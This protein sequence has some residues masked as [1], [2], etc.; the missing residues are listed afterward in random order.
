[1]Y[2]IKGYK[3]FKGH[4]GESC[5]QG[6]LYGPTGKKVAEWSDD[7]WGG[8]MHIRFISPEEEAKFA[9]HAKTALLAY[10]DFEDKPYEPATMTDYALVESLMLEMSMA[11][12]ETKQ[13]LELCKKGIGFKFADSPNQLHSWAVSYTQAN[14]DA[15]RKEYPG[16]VIT[17]LNEKHKLPFV[18]EAE[19]KAALLAEQ[20]KRYKRQCAT[21]ILFRL[22]K[23]DGSEVVM[24]ANAVYTPAHAAQLR[25]KYGSNLLEI[26]NERFK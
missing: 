2:K 14:V 7:T 9:E 23:S 24:K 18:T 15:L 26:I 1:M 20:E 6:S 5:A 17:I 8:S 12:G 11:C 22:K 25:A 19:E 21:A 4:E 3:T 13:E 10:K 16:K